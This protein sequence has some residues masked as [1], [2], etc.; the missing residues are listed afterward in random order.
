MSHTWY[1]TFEVQKRGVLPRARHPRL[2][3]TFETEAAAK[4]F[5]GEQFDQGL[6][7]TA[8]TLNPHLP[9]QTI[10]SSAIS[11]W[12]GRESNQGIKEIDNKKRT[13]PLHCK[14][15]SP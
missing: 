2:T 10:P 6:V 9:R 4:S 8:G 3:R 7:V 12:L 5:A 13:L 11:T 1:V 14:K 15:D